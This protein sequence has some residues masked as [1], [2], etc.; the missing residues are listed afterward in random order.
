MN[1]LLDIALKSFLLSVKMTLQLQ[2]V[3]KVDKRRLVD[4]RVV[5]RSQFDPTSTLSYNDIRSTVLD[6]LSSFRCLQ[7]L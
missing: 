2:L 3:G 4:M 1:L 7:S 5:R 6:G